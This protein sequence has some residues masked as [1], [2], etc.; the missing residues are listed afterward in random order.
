MK[1][2]KLTKGQFALVNDEDFEYLNQ[3]SWYCN[4]QGYAVR[5]PYIKGSGK[6][7][8]KSL[9][10]RMHI[11]VNNTPEGFETDHINRNRLDN[12]RENLRTVTSSQN[13]MNTNLR[14][15]NKSGV[16]GIHWENYTKKWRATIQANYKTISLGRFSDFKDAVLARKEAE[17]VYHA[18]S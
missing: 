17:G 5:K 12:R 4:A 1:Q 7:N 10:I 11:L 6:K 8:Q 2:I 13:R 18:I 14:I 16:K 9:L 15:D 3:W